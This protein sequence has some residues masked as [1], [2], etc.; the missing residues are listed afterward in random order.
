MNSIQYMIRQ[1]VC[2]HTLWDEVDIDG[3]FCIGIL[4]DDLLCYKL[5]ACVGSTITYYLS[6]HPG[7]DVAQR[8]VEEYC[9]LYKLLVECRVDT[10]RIQHFCRNQGKYMSVLIIQTFTE[11]ELYMMRSLVLAQLRG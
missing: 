4:V 3:G 9:T 5:S 8:L 7:S 11:S 10:R 6:A 2:K 1:S